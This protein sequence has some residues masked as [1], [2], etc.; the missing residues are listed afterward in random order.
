MKKPLTP[1]S[2]TTT[3]QRVQAQVEALVPLLNLKSL[4]EDNAPVEASALARTDNDKEFLKQCVQIANSM[5]ILGP[6]DQDGIEKAKAFERFMEKANGRLD[7]WKK[8]AKEESLA[9]NKAI[10]GRVRELRAMIDEAKQGC[11]SVLQP[12]LQAIKEKEEA[13]RAEAEA[14]F[15][16]R[17]LFLTEKMGMSYDMIQMRYVLQ[18]AQLDV[19]FVRTADAEMLKEAVRKMVLPVKERIDKAVQEAEREATLKQKEQDRAMQLVRAGMRLD[20]AGNVYDTT[21]II[22]IRSLRLYDE[23][24]FEELLASAK[25]RNKQEPAKPAIQAQPALAPAAASVSL[26]DEDEDAYTPGGVSDDLAEKDRELLRMA[27]MNVEAIM[28]MRPSGAIVQHAF[29]ELNPKLDYI[30]RYFEATLK[31]K[32]VAA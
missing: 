24:K 7:A 17:H 3:E 22:S 11:K 21:A 27:I 5:H 25:E 12:V 29:R 8:D 4:T 14:K 2:I 18:E 10:D 32:E 26:D 23:Q 28:A 9:F 15:K 19:E 13:E 20:D 1:A 16:K 31:S 6:E 30:K